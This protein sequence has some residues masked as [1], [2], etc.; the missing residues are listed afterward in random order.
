ME[1]AHEEKEEEALWEFYLHRVF[2]GSFEEFRDGLK[3]DRDNQT[4]SESAIE[5]TLKETQRILGNFNP[6]EQ[7]G[8]N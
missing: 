3:I 6:E 8:E 1:I 5:A 2:E 4:L 7:G